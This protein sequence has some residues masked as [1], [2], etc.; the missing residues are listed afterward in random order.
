MTATLI[1]N[2]QK[3]CSSSTCLCSKF[4]NCVF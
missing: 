2:I 4:Q 1:E 3:K